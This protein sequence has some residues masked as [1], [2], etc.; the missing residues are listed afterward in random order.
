MLRVFRLLRVFKLAKVWPSFN[1]IM[2]TV[3]NT[4]K[5]ISTFLLLLYIF[6]FLFTVLGMSLFAH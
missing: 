3:A 1:Y 5:K 2:M 4:I 6:L